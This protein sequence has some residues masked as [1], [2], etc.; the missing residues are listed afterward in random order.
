DVEKQLIAH[1]QEKQFALQL[2]ESTLRDNEAILLAYVRFNNEEPKELRAFEQFPCL[3]CVISDLQDE[4]LALY[5]Q[6]LENIYEDIQT[7]FSDLLGMDIPIW[8]PI[9][10]EVNVAKIE[11]SLQESLIE[12]QSDE[13]MR[14]KFK[15]G[16]YN[17]WKTNDVATNYPLLCDRV[18]FYVV[19]N[20]I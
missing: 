8:V 20:R 13:I 1:S 15:D 2:D 16:K 18:Q 3:A 14:A 19:A 11:L 10:F 17:I 4:D 5:G 12:L 7:R 9:P 6:Y